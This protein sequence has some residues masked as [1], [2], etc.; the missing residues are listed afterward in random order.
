MI[1]HDT[2]ST[3]GHSATG[4]PKTG[5][6]LNA[7]QTNFPGAQMYPT[8][9]VNNEGVCTYRPAMDGSVSALSNHHGSMY[10]DPTSTGSGNA[11]M[12]TPFHHTEGGHNSF[13]PAPQTFQHEWGKNFGNPSYSLGP[14]A[15]HRRPTAVPSPEG[16]S[17][18]AQSPT[19]FSASPGL[20]FGNGTPAHI[21]Y[22][23]PSTDNGAPPPLTMFANISQQYQGQIPFD[24][25]P[26][27]GLHQP[28]PELGASL[29]SAQFQQ[30]SPSSSCLATRPI[31][32]QK[33][34]LQSTQDEDD[35]A[36]E[37]FS[38][39]LEREIESLLSGNAGANAPQRLGTGCSPVTNHQATQSDAQAETTLPSTVTSLERALRSR[40][41]N[42]SPA[43]SVSD[44][45]DEHEAASPPNSA[46]AP[47]LANTQPKKEAPGGDLQ[48]CP[49]KPLMQPP[50][51]LG[52]SH[53]LET[54]CEH[55]GA[56][57]HSEHI[58]QLSTL[59]QGGS[60]T[61]AAGAEASLRPQN[62]NNENVWPGQ[63]NHRTR[64]QASLSAN[65]SPSRPTTNDARLAPQTQHVTSKPPP[66]ACVANTGIGHNELSFGRMSQDAAGGSLF[67]ANSVRS[68]ASI[69]THPSATNPSD[70]LRNANV[71]PGNLHSHD[72]NGTSTGAKHHPQNHAQQTFGGPSN[73]V[74]TAGPPYAPCPVVAP[75]PT[76]TYGPFPSHAQNLAQ[77]GIG[78]HWAG[79]HIYQAQNTTCTYHPPGSE[80]EGDLLFIDSN[81]HPRASPHYQIASPVAMPIFSNTSHGP[82]HRNTNGAPQVAQHGSNIGAFDAHMYSNHSASTF[83]NGNSLYPN[84]SSRFEHSGSAGRPLDNGIRTNARQYQF[85]ERPSGV[86]GAPAPLHPHLLESQRAEIFN[87][88]YRQHVFGKQPPCPRRASAASHLT[89]S[90]PRCEPYGATPAYG[91]TPQSSRAIKHSPKNAPNA[92]R[93]PAIPTVEPEPEGPHKTLLV[94]FIANTV[95]VEEIQKLFSAVGPLEGCRIIKDRKTNRSKGYAFVYFLHE[96]DA[97]RAKTLLGEPNWG[98]HNDPQLQAVVSEINLNV[99]PPPPPGAHVVLP[100]AGGPGV[101]LKGKRIKI[102]FSTNPLNQ[103]VGTEGAACDQEGEASAPRP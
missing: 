103:M 65:G 48:S 38:K 29:G 42:T 39:N 32:S 90:S 52:L 73:P 83:G 3:N 78:L 95:T 56:R 45:S 7:I 54:E 19:T 75:T 87:A 100:S 74:T 82:H 79:A 2:N 11:I 96:E 13:Q 70:L 47:A 8:P 22:Q 25:H 61:M 55:G 68:A 92:Q 88:Q 26:A 30:P 97:S 12:Q 18:A 10:Y 50:P 21:T 69:A 59:V 36:A 23:T 57:R 1:S 58:Q 80:S 41:R 5:T 66:L 81:R 86:A 76:N 6:C 35:A 72:A 85:Q 31:N 34:E 98:G 63:S 9:F 60:T 53:P 46:E 101:S 93:K 51:L 67:L 16:F 91:T 14:H 17:A 84:T 33:A 89:T 102:S 20:V 99:P 28:H 44:V 37:S 24:R 49:P 15:P 4:L 43:L 64:P 62:P 94:N 27:F 71:T 77:N 40:G